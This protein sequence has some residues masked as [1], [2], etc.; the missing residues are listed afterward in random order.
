MIKVW[1]DLIL[2]GRLDRLNDRG[3]TFSY[4]PGADPLQAVLEVLK[5]HG[6][7]DDFFKAA[8]EGSNKGDMIN[9]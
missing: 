6:L 3:T 1:S 9:E 4:D 7:L 5:K 8:Q 2:S